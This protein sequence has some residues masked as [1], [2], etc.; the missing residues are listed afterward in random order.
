MCLTGGNVQCNTRQCD[1]LRPLQWHKMLPR[2][3]GRQVQKQAGRKDWLVID[4][5]GEASLN[6]GV[7]LRVTHFAP[8]SF[9]HESCVFARSTSFRM[10]FC[11]FNFFE[12]LT[13]F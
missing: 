11:A 10:S 1:K 6:A 12:Q 7:L 5:V 8:H 9:A 2:F 13:C 3:T 4:M